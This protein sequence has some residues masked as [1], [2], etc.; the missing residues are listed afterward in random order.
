MGKG[1]RGKSSSGTSSA[2]KEDDDK[3]L[4][5]AIAENKIAKEQ[6]QQQQADGAK[7]SGR[8]PSAGGASSSSEPPKAALTVGEI[9]QKLNAV[10]CFCM[11]NSESDLVTLKDPTDA[12]GKKELCVWFSCPNEAKTTLETCKVANPDCDGLHLGV[13][14]LGIAY[15]FACG[16][17]ECHFYGE[18]QVRGSTEV[19]AGA[20]DPIPLLRDQ[21]VAQGLEPQSWHVPVFTCDELSSPGRTPIFM[22]RKALAESWVVSGR[23][24]AELPA[25]IAVLDLGVVVHQMQTDVFAWSTIQFVCER[26][27]V[28]L[29]NESK[30][31]S[32]TA[33]SKAADAS[34]AGSDEAPPPL[35]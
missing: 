25:N 24:L 26:K 30:Q 11:L 10:P 35:S 5:A 21:A 20:Q 27:A 4:A 22:S 31:A 29:V 9:V 28:Q 7:A 16:W 19:F 15:A 3:L 23:K 12:T 13:T 1:G 17:A 34:G 6:Q 14:P 32:I 2:S 33:R 18:K 8:T